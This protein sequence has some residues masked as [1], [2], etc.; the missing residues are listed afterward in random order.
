[1]KAKLE[2]AQN[3]LNNILGVTNGDTLHKLRDFA[4]TIIEK[5]ASP[6]DIGNLVTLKAKEFHGV[7]SCRATVTLSL[8]YTKENIDYEV[9][10]TAERDATKGKKTQSHIFRDSEIPKMN[11]GAER[12]RKKS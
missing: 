10:R 9:K 4:H 7:D 12:V 6:E 5:L 11:F 3:D 8:K 1:M 2:K